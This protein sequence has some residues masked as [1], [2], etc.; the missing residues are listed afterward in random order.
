MP[1]FEYLYVFDYTTGS[2]YQIDVSGDER[3][4]EEIISSKGL[5]SDDC[6]FMYSEKEL[7]IEKL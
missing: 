2:I 5:K 6:L 7:T 3:E 1:S 4:A